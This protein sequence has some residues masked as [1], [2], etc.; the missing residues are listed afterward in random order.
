MEITRVY[1]NSIFD[2]PKPQG[3]RQL[4]KK[5]PPNSKRTKEMQRLEQ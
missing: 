3:H 1:L 4:H 2:I 5:K